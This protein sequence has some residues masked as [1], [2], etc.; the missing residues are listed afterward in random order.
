MLKP[1][2]TKIWYVVKFY[3]SQKP[4]DMLLI[5][6]MVWGKTWFFKQKSGILRIVGFYKYVLLLAILVSLCPQTSWVRLGTGNPCQNFSKL[7]VPKGFFMHFGDK[8]GW[9]HY[10]H[11]RFRSL[12]CWYVLMIN[13]KYVLLTAFG[14]C[15]QTS[16]VRL[17]TGNP[18]PNVS[19][20]GV[21]KGVLA[22]FGG[23]KRVKPL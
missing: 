14:L 17:G 12:L 2:S 13:F 22:H 15:P 19:K 18:C 21:P 7:G 8:K 5:H 9:K 23:K 1:I 6:S 11:C 10:I 20:I 16:L 3:E 4:I